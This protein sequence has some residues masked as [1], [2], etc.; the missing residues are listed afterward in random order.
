MKYTKQHDVKADRYYVIY[1]KVRKDNERF[2]YTIKTI[3]DYNIEDDSE[4]N[5]TMMFK[6]VELFDY[7]PKDTKYNM[8]SGYCRFRTNRRTAQTEFYELDD[9]EVLMYIVSAEV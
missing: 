9:D 8:K 3:S 2:Q 5:Y 4:E 1:H 6:K 7:F